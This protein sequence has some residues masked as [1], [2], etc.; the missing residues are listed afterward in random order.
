MSQYDHLDRDA[1]IRLLQRRDA[2]RQLGLVWERDEHSGGALEA[3]NALNDDYVALDLDPALSHGDAPWQ[4]MIIEGDNY[5]ALR[6]L[7]M[8]HKSAIRCIYID[9]LYNTGNRDFVYND[10][11]IDKTHRFRHSLW[12]VFMYRRLTLAKE[13]LAD[14]GVIFVSA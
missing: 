11:F 13:L 12:L 10:R 5:D 4:N 8:S 7:R 3:D 1:L 2:E 6:A 14:D 9:P